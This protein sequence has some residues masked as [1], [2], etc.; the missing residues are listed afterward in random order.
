MAVL[1]M[2]NSAFVRS[3]S[4]AD[5]VRTGPSFSKHHCWTRNHSKECPLCRRSPQGSCAEMFHTDQSMPGKP[6]PITDSASFPSTLVVIW[7]V[8]Q[9]GA[10][11]LSLKTTLLSCAS[12]HS[13]IEVIPPDTISQMR[14]SWWLKEWEFKKWK[15]LKVY[16]WPPFT[17]IQN[18]LLWKHGEMAQV[19]SGFAVFIFMV[20]RWSPRTW[21]GYRNITT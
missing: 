16:V 9:S 17:G 13:D 10:C 18:S 12:V 20:T 4:D 14:K 7:M 8:G 19:T 6:P 11:L 3:C 2:D 5:A 15:A 21:A 1:C